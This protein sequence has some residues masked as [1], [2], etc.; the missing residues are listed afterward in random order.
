M[1]AE[2]RFKAKCVFLTYPQ[3]P[4]TKEEVLAAL[5]AKLGEK[6]GTH[7]LIGQERHEDGNYHLHVYVERETDI[8]TRN[9]RYFDIGEYHPNIVAPRDRQATKKYITKED[10]EPLVWPAEWNWEEKRKGKW[11]EATP[12][13][14]AGQDAETL[15]KAMP[16]FVLGNLKKVQEAVAFVANIKRQEEIPPLEVFLTWE[17][18]GDITSTWCNETRT[19]WNALRDN[20]TNKGFGRRQ[21]YLHGPTGIGKSTFLQHL[22]ASLRVFY[23]PVEDFYDL[24]NDHLYDLSV[25]EEFKS[26]KT[27]QWFNQWLDGATMNVRKKGSQALKKNPVPTIV[28][29]NFDIHG[30]EV[31]PNM[32]ESTSLETL[33]RR[34]QSVLVNRE[35]MHQLT[36]TLRAFLSFAGKPL[37]HLPPPQEQPA[38]QPGLTLTNG[39]RHQS[40]TANPLWRGETGQ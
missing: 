24:W 13:L 31:Y 33:R 18:P 27:I 40:A 10:K 1:S 3:C 28:L 38:W 20:L 32:Q 26:Q 22:A 30:S 19:V 2:Y 37:P 14:L 35:S 12:L 29:S 8:C 4:L 36:A 16:E 7:Y 11:S 23:I 6:E 25:M 17:P 21:L 9:A 5:Q 15:L 39:F 34:F